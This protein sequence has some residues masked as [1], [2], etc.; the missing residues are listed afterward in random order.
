MYHTVLLSKWTV[1]LLIVDCG[2]LTVNN[3]MVDTSSGTTFMN[4]ATYT[5]NTGYTLVGVNNR[6]CQADAIWSRTAP[7]CF[8]KNQLVYMYTHLYT[9][10]FFSAD[11]SEHGHYKQYSTITSSH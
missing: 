3:G 4:T 5:C 8:C 10:F 9:C 6:T 2:P 7:V 11:F 1:Y